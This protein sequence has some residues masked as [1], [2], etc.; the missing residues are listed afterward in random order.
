[1]S[2]PFEDDSTLDLPMPDTLIDRSPRI[3]RA[4]E[5]GDDEVRDAHARHGG[6]ANKMAA[7]L[8]VSPVGL[9]LRIREL[10]G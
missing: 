3:R 10:L 9:R 4:S 8:Q 6:D 2:G 5:V 1:M 7:E